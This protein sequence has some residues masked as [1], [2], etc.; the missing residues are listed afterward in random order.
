MRKSSGLIDVSKKGK[1][2][3]KFKRGMVMMRSAVK[4]S[5]LSDVFPI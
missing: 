2:G 1:M 4:K 5:I 3:K